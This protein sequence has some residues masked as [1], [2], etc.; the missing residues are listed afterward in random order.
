MFKNKNPDGT[1]NLCGK[2]VA[3]LRKAKNLSQK[4]LADELQRKGLDVG[5]NMVQQVESGERF[6][7]DIELKVIAEYFAVTADSL[8]LER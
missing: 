8:L 1:L 6:V 5:K 3:T 4:E 7:T 2:Y